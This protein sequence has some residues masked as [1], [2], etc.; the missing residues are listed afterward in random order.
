MEQPQEIKLEFVGIDDH[1]RPVFKIP[2]VNK[3]YGSTN[4]L[5]S[6]EAS[7]EEVLEQVDIF[8]LC[9]FGSKF[10]CEPYGGGIDTR[11]TL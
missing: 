1:N 5:F 10:N 3:Y 7:E 9:Y 8:D 4:K 2:K 6:Y 11:L